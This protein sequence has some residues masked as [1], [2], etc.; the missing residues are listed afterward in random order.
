M[1]YGRHVGLVVDV[2][3][4][5]A[6]RDN[7]KSARVDAH[8]GLECLGDEGG[9]RLINSG[10]NRHRQGDRRGLR[11]RLRRQG[12]RSSVGRRRGLTR[13]QQTSSNTVSMRLMSVFSYSG[14]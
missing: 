11:R 5:R 14:R 1:L 12:S 13:H 2:H 6:E 3:E 4:F 9:G 10:L 7:H 8:G